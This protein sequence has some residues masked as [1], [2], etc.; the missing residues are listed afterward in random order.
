M[1]VQLTITNTGLICS[2]PLIHGFFSLSSYY[3]PTQLRLIESEDAEPWIQIA[4]CK[5]ILGI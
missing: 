1:C 3:S 4:N 5:V 2:G